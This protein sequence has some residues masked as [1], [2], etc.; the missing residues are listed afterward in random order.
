AKANPGKLSY[1][2]QGNGTTS[3][4]TMELLKHQ[5]GLNIVHVPYR[6][7]APA[8]TDMLG[9]TIDLMFDNSPSTLPHVTAQKLR[10][11]GV[12]SA[13]RVAAMDSVPALSETVKGFESTAWF[14]L[15]VA[16]GTPDAVIQQLNRAVN[17]ALAQNDMKEKFAASGVQLLGGK[18]EDL[19]RHMRSESDKWA[20]VVRAS[21]AKLE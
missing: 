9:G 7:R 13:Q 10:A 20:E 17:A 19:A 2:S 11:L 4:L 12:A 3:H 21:G 14:A 1:G 15:V 16:A 6:G 18:P 5:A 8:T